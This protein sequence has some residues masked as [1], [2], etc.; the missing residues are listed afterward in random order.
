MTMGG[1]NATSRH[2]DKIRP[3]LIGTEHSR[4]VASWF[5]S[6]IVGTRRW[7]SEEEQAVECVVCVHTREVRSRTFVIQRPPNR[8]AVSARPLQ[9][10]DPGPSKRELVPLHDADLLHITRIVRICARRS[11]LTIISASR[12]RRVDALCSQKPSRRSHT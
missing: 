12:A 7:R 3:L 8:P 10:T 4:R 9:T 5:G 1:I 6:M 2:I 11:C